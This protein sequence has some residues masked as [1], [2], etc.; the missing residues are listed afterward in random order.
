MGN[1]SPL[2]RKNAR[3]YPHPRPQIQPFFHPTPLSEVR[4]PAAPG[5]GERLQETFLPLFAV[6]PQRP[7]AVLPP[8]RPRLF[9]LDCPCASH[10]WPRHPPLGGGTSRR[11]PC[12]REGR[13]L[14]ASRFSDRPSTPRLARNARTFASHRHSV[15]DWEDVAWEP[16]RDAGIVRKHPPLRESAGGRGAQKGMEGMERGGGR[17][18]GGWKIWRICQCFP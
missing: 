2:P 8:A 15:F 16:E 17:R 1:P 6:S 11:S 7:P 5:S 9:P 4:R 12:T 13:A 10:P 18:A 3:H 14:R